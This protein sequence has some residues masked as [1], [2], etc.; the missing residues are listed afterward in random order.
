[1][2]QQR[3]VS[4]IIKC[5]G[6]KARFE[7]ER[8][9]EASYVSCP[10]CDMQVKISGSMERKTRSRRKLHHAGALPG[11][12][13]ED[14]VQINDLAST[15]KPLID[16]EAAK[17][18]AQARLKNDD[19]DLDDVEDLGDLPKRAPKLPKERTVKLTSD[20]GEATKSVGHIGKLERLIAKKERLQKLRDQHRREKGERTDTVPVKAPEPAVEKKGS[21]TAKLKADRKPLEAKEDAPE[22]APQDAGAAEKP[23]LAESAPKKDEPK[24]SESVTQSVS[25]EAEAKTPEETAEEGTATK[26]RLK[27]REEK[28]EGVDYEKIEVRSRGERRRL[29]QAPKAQVPEP[30]GTPE[31][32]KPVDL[33]TK[34]VEQ[35]REQAQEDLTVTQEFDERKIT[36]GAEWRRHQPNRIE[37][38]DWESDE[39]REEPLPYTRQD[40]W[41]GGFVIG[42]VTLGAAMLILAGFKFIVSQ[43]SDDQGDLEAEQEVL[44]RPSSPK[45]W[46]KSDLLT[47]A[48][49]VIESFFSSTSNEEALQ[50]VRR[51]GKISLFMKKHYAP[52]NF[53]PVEFAELGPAE[54]C[55]IVMDGFFVV[56]VQMPDFTE[57]GLALQIPNGVT[58]REWKV[59][60]E[61][62]EGYSEMSFP[63]IRI[64]KPREP[65]IIRAYIIQDEYYNF[66]FSDSEQYT[67]YKLFDSARDQQ[68]WAYANKQSEAYNE[69][70]SGVVA[71]ENGSLEEEVV[72]IKVRAPDSTSNPSADQVEITE[73]IT[74]G[75]VIR[76]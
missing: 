59:D 47:E 44:S 65:I 57:R 50:F 26:Q 38:P 45:D 40:R 31:M 10:E 24:T 37:D 53:S 48:T 14:R 1:M 54:K 69:L 75:W 17:K 35:R 60:W 61:S 63:E 46:V 72:T 28:E 2:A 30:R 39:D 4:I 70:T 58:T 64:R 34:V 20:S 68:L 55:S 8:E 7:A 49:P 16:F 23:A 56:P 21:P 27:K 29:R 52:N 33:R 62:W 13:N 9:E 18:R 3:D 66:E 43:I 51:P 15:S 41:F 74:F 11:R 42:A 32:P 6:C 19:L 73:F 67:S 71:N 76:D 12:R 22:S 36:E 5:P 25:E